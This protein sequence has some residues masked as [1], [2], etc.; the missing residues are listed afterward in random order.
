[1]VRR[2]ILYLVILLGSIAFYVA[3]QQ[4]LGWMLLVLVLA[5]PFF[6]L[7]VSLPAMLS[8]RAS[9]RCAG[10]LEKHMEEVP[11]FHLVCRFPL[12]LTRGKIRVRRTITG[13][14][15]IL[16]PKEKLPTD[17]CGQLVCQPEKLMI[18][19]YLALFR[20]K[21]T[22]KKSTSVIVRPDRISMD[23]PPDLDRHLSRSWKPKPGGGFSE[24][25]E[26]R[27][28]RPGDSLN[29]VHWKLTAKTGKLVVREAMEPQLGRMLLTMNL[30]GSPEILDRNFAELLWMGRHL[31][32]M[33]MRFEIHVLTG[34]GAWMR[35]VTNEPELE[36]A[37]D[38]LLSQPPAEEG[39]ILDRQIP[40]SW[41]CH[42][43]GETGEA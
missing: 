32:Q 28:Y 29:Q 34:I 27:L 5:I 9:V 20:L 14:S 37:I 13:E 31:L 21:V 41:R 25:H 24:N 30:R 42:I 17:H 22:K 15:W 23:A 8:A 18:Y 16:K 19:D 40:A 6:S 43:G 11:N 39:S 33:G 26:L 3:N 7:L 4:W 12:S 36:K 2:W 1:M 38:D 10:I 35:T